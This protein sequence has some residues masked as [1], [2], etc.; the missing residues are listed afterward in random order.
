MLYIFIS[1]LSG[2]IPFGLILSN[3]FGKGNLRETG[4]K[5]IGA[6]NVVRTQ[7]KFLGAMTFLLD[8]LKAFLPCYFLSTANPA[9]NLFIIMAPVIGHMFPVWLM[10]KGGKGVASYFGILLALDPYVFLFTILVWLFVFLISKISAV[11]GITSIVLS[12]IAYGY[13]KTLLNLEFINENY[14]LLILALIIVI[15]HHENI[16]KLCSKIICH[17]K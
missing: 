17:T 6:T 15:R 1:Y 3:L 8:F 7:G 9:I 4:S 14:V 2:S 10:F 16:K 13:H 12:V 5:N 11:A